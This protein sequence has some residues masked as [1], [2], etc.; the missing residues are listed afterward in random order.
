M[1]DTPQIKFFGTTF[2]PRKVVRF[3]S[4]QLY[5]LHP[6]RSVALDPALEAEGVV[7]VPMALA[8]EVGVDL[9]DAAAS[10]MSIRF[11]VVSP[12]FLCP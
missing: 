11:M 5:H 8:G 4:F 12:L 2:L 6:H 7:S 3:Y 10:Q 1:N 9:E